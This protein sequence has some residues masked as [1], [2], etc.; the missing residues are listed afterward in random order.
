[1]EQ[2]ANALSALAKPIIL[3]CSTSR[4]VTLPPS[5]AIGREFMFSARVGHGAFTVDA[6]K[7][8]L[9]PVLHGL[10][11]MRK[12][13]ALADNDLTAYRSLHAAT[14]LLL[15]G[16]GVPEPP[17]EPYDDWMAT[18]RFQTAK[19]HVRGSGV[20]P[21]YYAILAGRTDLINELLDRG[22][23]LSVTC[24]KNV[25]A[26]GIMQGAFPLV[27][28]AV[29]ARDGA[30]IELL[31]RR[32]AD[33]RQKMQPLGDSALLAATIC[34]NAEGVRALMR[35]DAT[36]ADE[37][38]Y[39]GARPF[40]QIW[41]TG[42]PAMFATLRHEYPRQL[43]ATVRT[44]DTARL[45]GFGLNAYAIANNAAHRE[46]LGATLDLGEPIDRYTPKVTGFF[47]P[48]IAL[49]SL[50]AGMRPIHKLPE[51][52]FVLSH[53]FRSSAIHFAAYFGNVPAL[54]LLIERGADIH[55]T[56]SPKTMTPLILGAIGGH[57]DVCE[58]LLEL[59]ALVGAKDKRGRTALSY[60]KKLGHED[61][62]RRLLAHASDVPP[63]SVTGGA[64]ATSVVDLNAQSV[65]V[66][67]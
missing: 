28:A 10:V 59:G 52:V 7:L 46:L 50:A 3:A 61:V 63:A 44:L 18:M 26:F 30:V 40:F 47:K 23:P 22:A 35:H 8:V 56:A 51:F 60:A 1:M 66:S 31:L 34:G 65:D 13:L 37:P 11:S 20:T 41:A 27:V 12:A 64:G 55:S 19:D 45:G 9:G 32:G 17:P 57:D 5:G 43:E 54:E 67:A 4:I 49:M 42:H 58:R 38:G 14:S 36:L 53:L 33:P 21:L 48:V 15:D 16:C 6:D 29:T 2:T 62:V 39:I 24:K 25:P